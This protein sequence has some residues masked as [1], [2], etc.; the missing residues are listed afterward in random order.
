MRLYGAIP[1][2]SLSLLARDILNILC[3]GC[4]PDCSEGLRVEFEDVFERAFVLGLNAFDID[5]QKMN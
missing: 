5:A 2:A 1:E 4:F 3:W